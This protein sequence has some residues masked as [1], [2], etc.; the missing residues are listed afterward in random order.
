MGQEDGTKGENEHP[1]DQGEEEEGGSES[2]DATGEGGGPQ[3]GA[4]ACTHG[5]DVE[6]AAASED[7][8]SSVGMEVGAENEE[9]GSN[10]AIATL[11]EG[12]GPADVGSR[13]PVIVG[14]GAVL[15]TPTPEIRLRAI[16]QVGERIEGME[17]R[18]AIAKLQAKVT[19]W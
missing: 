7:T 10:H 4:A 13:P 16:G 14:R 19:L 11:N 5:N 8:G 9:A 3:N 6:K 1:M 15:E 17:Q 18:L 2:G 12:A